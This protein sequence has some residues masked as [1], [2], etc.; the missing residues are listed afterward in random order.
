MNYLIYERTDYQRTSRAG[1][2]GERWVPKRVMD[3][4]EHARRVEA[5]RGVAVSAATELSNELSC[6]KR[7]ETYKGNQKLIGPPKGGGAVPG[8]H[9]E[10][11]A[12][13]TCVRR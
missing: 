7:K 10:K 12:P 13:E 6:K 11:T 2:P 3:I 1:E 8:T 4:G 9:C 5:C